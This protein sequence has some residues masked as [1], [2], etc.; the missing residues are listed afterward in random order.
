M[1]VH[2][3]SLFPEMLGSPLA[4]GV[5]KRARDRGLLEV[6]LHQLRDYA[7]GR[8]LQVDDTPYGGG[9][10]MVMMA[11]PL[12]AAIE[13]V[14]AAERP[15]RILLSPRGTPFDHARAHALAAEPALLL[16][17]ARYEGVDERV[18]P[19]VDEELSIGDYVLSGGELAALVVLDAVV[20]LLPGA[21]G[22]E[23][24]PADDSFA[25]GLLEHPQY[26]RPEVF[27]GARVPDVLLGG[28]HA[29]I[30]R[31][32]REESLRMTLARRPDLLARAPLTADDREFLRGLGWRADG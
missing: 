4:A 21:V 23:A 29:A 17:C 3:L 14:A 5:L 16:V 13:H 2:V 7:S 1:R 15:R 12:V 18:V 19:Y 28:D 32:R 25:T 22:N 24:S 30:A 9:Q 20:R 10:G 26:T 27:R 11:E 6:F 8:H 31:S